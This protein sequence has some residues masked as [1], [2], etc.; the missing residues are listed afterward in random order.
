MSATTSTPIQFGASY[1]AE[2][3]VVA[4]CLTNDDALATAL[5]L[6]RPDDFAHKGLGLI[7]WA[8]LR[9]FEAGQ[10]VDA[11]TVSDF[12]RRT[13]YLEKAGGVER[14]NELASTPAAPDVDAY[15]RIVK[16]H[17]IRRGLA[18]AGAEIAALS[19]DDSGESVETLLDR[20]QQVVFELGD[21]AETSGPEK[22]G[23]FVSEVLALI[24]ERA[25]RGG[26]L[27][28]FPTGYEAVDAHL[29]GYVPGDL[30]LVAGRPSMGK[31]AFILGTAVEAAVRGDPVLLFSLEM[32]KA[33]I[34]MRMLSR[35]SGVPLRAIVRG[36]LES[37]PIVG[38]DRDELAKAARLLSD[39]PLWI[40]DTPALS[41]AQMR[42]RVRRWRAQ[43]PGPRAL[44]VVDYLQLMTPPKAEG[45]VQEVSKISA[46]LKAIAR[47][48]DVSLV[49]LSQLSRS[50][51]NR[52]D[53]R[54]R[55]SDLRES[56]SLEQ[57]ADVVLFLFRPEYYL[58]ESEVQS[59]GIRG[60]GELIVAK[61]RNG[62]TGLVYLH[63]DGANAAYRNAPPELV[64]R[65]R[66][67]A[68]LERKALSDARYRRRGDDDE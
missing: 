64:E 56:G 58:T 35:I 4:A 26:G 22:A 67:A 10:L 51:E 65:W 7:Y 57:D 20:A 39:A 2:M 41:L 47:E 16:E 30:V 37:D 59:R 52:I 62:P 15:A 14:I 21:R 25:N 29:G 24:D 33:S 66:A 5:E 60:C 49:A 68:E 40:D 42:T 61:F 44:V 32:D 48:F 3:A 18:R 13:G 23:D 11:V 31:S 38:N 34:A 63:W 50:V 55:L 1:E 45:R 8:A 27:I 53:F 6:L 43:N 17:A 54:P 36:E 46:G 12:L 28:G 9:L 19:R